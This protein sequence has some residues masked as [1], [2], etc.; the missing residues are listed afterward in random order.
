MEGYA[1][2]YRRRVLRRH[3]PG[4]SGGTK[5][6][7]RDRGVRAFRTALSWLRVCDASRNKGLLDTELAHTTHKKQRRT[8]RG[9]DSPPTRTRAS[10]RA[11]PP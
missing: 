3:T 11:H 10:R 8:W 5:R 2:A 7:E 1:G 9:R 4:A 6:G